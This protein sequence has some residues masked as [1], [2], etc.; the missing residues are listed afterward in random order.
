MLKVDEH[1]GNLEKNVVSNIDK[2]L[3]TSKSITIIEIIY[4]QRF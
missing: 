4:M 1:L 2:P 3:I